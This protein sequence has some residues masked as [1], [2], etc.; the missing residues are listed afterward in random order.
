MRVS[1][2]SDV[3]TYRALDKLIVGDAR[4]MDEVPGSSVALVVTSPPDFAGKEYEETLGEAAKAAY[5]PPIWSAPGQAEPVQSED[6]T[7]PNARIAD[8]LAPK[9]ATRTGDFGEFLA[10]ALYA[11]VARV[12]LGPSVKLARP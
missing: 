9:G 10:A 3:A 4:R 12:G 5:P 6:S 1:S 8:R 11:D 7:H 2:E